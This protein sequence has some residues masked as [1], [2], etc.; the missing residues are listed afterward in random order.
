[1]VSVRLSE[2]AEKKLIFT[3]WRITIVGTPRNMIDFQ[4]IFKC[5]RTKVSV[6]FQVVFHGFTVQSD[7][8]TEMKQRSNALVIFQQG[9]DKSVHVLKAIKQNCARVFRQRIAIKGVTGFNWNYSKL[10]WMTSDLWSHQAEWVKPPT[11]QGRLEVPWR[12][13]VGDIQ[14]NRPSLDY[15]VLIQFRSDPLVRWMQNAYQEKSFLVI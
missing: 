3:K 2:V 11:M 9:K 4:S 1:M 7:R 12:T 14:K 6:G 15:C 13:T 10:A 5:K 8:N